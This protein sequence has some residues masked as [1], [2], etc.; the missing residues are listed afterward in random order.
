MCGINLLLDLNKSLSSAEN[1]RLM[2]EATRHRGPD[3]QGL[4]TIE[5]PGRQVFIANNRL[6]IQDLGEQGNQPMQCGEKG[7]AGD[8]FT[9]SYNGELYNHYELK[10]ELLQKGYLF[11]STS[12]TE[13][14]L[15]ALAE[16]GE[17]AVE[18][19]KGMFAFAFYDGVKEQ[20]ITA[21]D[22]HGMKPLYYFSNEHYLLISSEIKGI[23]ASRLVK[24]ELN[25]S[26]I[27]HYLHFRYAKKPQTFYR[28]IYELLPGHLLSHRA[29]E[30]QPRIT[31]TA[32]P[33]EAP[34]DVEQTSASLLQTVEEKLTDALFSHL[35]TDR[36]PG[37]FLS[38][39]IDSTLMLALLRNN[40]S[41]QIP[42]CFTIV[43]SEKEA[44]WGTQDYLWA[45][46]AAKKF[47]ARHFPL[48]VGSSILQ[49]FDTFIA[50]QDQPIGDSAAWLT[51]ILSKEAINKNIHVI[52]NGA[53]AD[54]LF[55]GYNRHAAFYTYLQH[56]SKLRPLF[57]WFK[58]LGNILPS[59][60]I[61]KLRKP[62][63]L[64]KKILRDMDTSPSQTFLN[65]LSFNILSGTSNTGPEKEAG[66]FE[67]GW[68]MA[69]LQH[70]RNNYL[71][72]DILA[73]N[74]KASMRH[75]L[76][77]RMP[78]LSDEVAG[79]AGSL[80]ADLLMKNGPKWILAEILRK[81][82]AEDF[83]KRKKEG[84]GLP[85]GLWVKEGKTEFMWSWLNNEENP[86]LQHLG[87]DSI[88]HLLS[89]HKSGRDDFSQELFSIAVLGHWLENEFT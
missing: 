73:L 5:H 56:Y 11:R 85:F 41:Y 16:W 68:M 37:M 14:L 38:G 75:G 78:Y 2:S 83:V 77:M 61:N 20:L 3:Y 33:A 50:E 30:S 29:G 82:G 18:R 46:R 55:G 57:P 43:N 45:S 12:D 24:K 25:D 87:K 64:W 31:K 59:G 19:L 60:K 28:N 44:A 40:S 10:N 74:D 62:L 7:R 70:D 32:F 58:P 71:I 8:R 17:N 76:E 86:L 39:G 15:Y 65:F 79:F 9:L 21:R 27:P 63:R 34:Y 36:S 6:K 52:L 89:M 35:E 23:L 4:L 81:N 48:E 49:T 54:E 51:S 72:S 13:V 53:G 1:I 80:P 66:S 26:Q 69:A 47:D 88:L 67:E 22:R 42:D 84:F